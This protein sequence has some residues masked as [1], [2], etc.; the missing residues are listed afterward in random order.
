MSL[1]DEL[2]KLEELW[3]SGGLSD[4]EYAKAKTALL[5]AVSQPELREH[6]ADQL[7]EVKY[8]NKLAQID[9]EWQIERQQY[10]IRSRYGIAQ[11]PTAGMGIGTALI[12]GAF[13]VFWTMLALSIAGAAPH[14]TSDFS[15][16]IRIFFPLFG[17]VFTV[18]AIGGG[19]YACIKAQKYQEAFAAYQE[20]RARVKAGQAASADLPRGPSTPNHHVK[21]A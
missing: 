11:V 19:I 4:A 6:L 15:S 12:G 3:R 20:R 14:P 18:A 16:L 17:I 5:N 8:Q 10:L 21:P 7:T 9:R 2:A 13:G 1:V